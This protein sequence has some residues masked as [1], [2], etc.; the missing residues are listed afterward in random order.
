MTAQILAFERPKEKTFEPLLDKSGK[1]VTGYLVRKATGVIYYR[2]EFKKLKIPA[3]FETT[4]ETTIGRARAKAT[5][6]EQ[7]HKN[8]HLGIEDAHVFGVRKV[9]KNFRAVAEYV[10]TNYT[11]TQR[12]RTQENHRLY[13][14]E[15]AEVLGGRD[16]NAITTDVLDDVIKAA[17]QKRR[18]SKTGKPLPVRTTFMDYAKALNLVMRI[19]Y[20]KKWATHLVKFENPD[21]K[22]ETGRLLTRREV[23]ALYEAMNDD[24]RDQ[25]VL[26]LECVMRL[27]EAIQ[28]PWSE[29]DLT[30]GIWTLP[31][32]RVKTGSK[33]GKGR[34]FKLSQNALERLRA[35]HARC[36]KSS[37]WIFPSPENLQKPIWSIKT[38]WATAKR[39]AN[40]KGKCRW[41]DLRH[42]GLTWMILGDPDASDKVR[43]QMTREPIKVAQF[44]GVTMKTIEAVYLK[45]R[46]KHTEDVS[47][48]IDL[49]QTA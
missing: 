12:I 26:A 40:I 9:D 28:A 39:N 30:T 7:Q 38:A 23:V 13:I 8:K 43:A 41:H 18:F 47:S 32:E 17:K 14:N 2:K 27:R 33:T 21:K 48:A 3:L 4:G 20:E 46:A 19:A 36:N 35:R 1:R 5:V 6:L 24:T 10:L 37:P 42:T 44:A 25:F 45:S 22:K 11:P 31:P 49:F 34:S 16:I 15:L 29:I